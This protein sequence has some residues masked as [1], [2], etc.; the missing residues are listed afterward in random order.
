MLPESFQSNKFV[1]P[2]G[3]QWIALPRS[4]AQGGFLR[5]FLGWAA[6]APGCAKSVARGWLQGWHWRGRVASGQAAGEGLTP[7]SLVLVLLGTQTVAVN[8]SS[9]TA[10]CSGPWDARGME[11]SV[12]TGDGNAESLYMQGTGSPRPA[13]KGVA[14]SSSPGRDLQVLLPGPPFNGFQPFLGRGGSP[15]THPA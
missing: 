14:L 1:E 9:P 10:G 12:P 13:W 6:G 3:R 2:R 8:S 5:R 15:E 7:H 11:E 4:G